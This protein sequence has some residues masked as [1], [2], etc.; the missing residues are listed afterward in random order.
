MCKRLIGDNE[1][2]A[3][4][5]KCRDG[6]LRLRTTRP[7]ATRRPRVSRRRAAAASRLGHPAARAA[8]PLCRARLAQRAGGPAF[9][10]VHPRRA[11][12]DRQLVGQVETHLAQDPGDGSGWEVLA[13]VYMRLGRFD[14]AVKRE[15]SAEA[16]R[17]EC[18][19]RS[20]PRRGR[21]RSREGH[22][23][24]RG[25]GGIRTRCRR[26]SAEPRPVI[27]SGLPPNRTARSKTPPPCGERCWPMRRPARSGL[28]SC[29]RR[30]RGRP[31]RRSPPSVRPPALPPV[32]PQRCR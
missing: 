13:P 10:R 14:E 29:V 2:E 25:E 28:A 4:R 6:C 20:R 1:A 19:P 16:Q 22:G 7:A 23:D 12:I 30:W 11:T 9:A 3:A 21:D 5:S 17:R 31:E 8:R 26:R 18:D 24:G 27:F 15:E 32:R